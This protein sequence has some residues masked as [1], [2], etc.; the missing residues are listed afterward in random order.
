MYSDTERGHRHC[1]T[2]EG[3]SVI[4]ASPRAALGVKEVSYLLY[5]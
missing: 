4:V 5:H 3:Q 2:R 1:E